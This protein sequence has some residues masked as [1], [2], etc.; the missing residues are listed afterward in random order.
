MAERSEVIALSLLTAG[1]MAH[2]FSAF[3]PS[4]FTIR[5]WVLDGDHRQVREKVASL[6][7]G[8]APALVFG[9]GLG[10]VVAVIARSPLP[11]LF[12][13]ATGA[14]LVHLYEQ[15]LPA[16]MRLG[17][18]ELPAGAGGSSAWL[19]DARARLAMEV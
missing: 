13:A 2:A 18:P 14:A 19:T 3:M 7:S 17:R 4:R 16:E 9:L 15:A 11:L 10:G 5:N 12:S 6:R 1:E 8:Y